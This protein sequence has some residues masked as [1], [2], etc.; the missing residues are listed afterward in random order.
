MR[1]AE[2]ASNLVVVLTLAAATP[3]FAQGAGSSLTLQNPAG[4]SPAHVII[5]GA[6]WVCQGAT[7]TAGP[8]GQDQPVERAC[9]RVVRELGPVSAFSWQGQPLRPDRLAAC[10]TAATAAKR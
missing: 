6:A 10:N 4:A 9:R 7:C 2:I 5:D 1:V 8:G 3:S